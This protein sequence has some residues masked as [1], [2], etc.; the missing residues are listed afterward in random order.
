MN[1]LPL[2]K[3][4]LD[5]LIKRGII[6]L[7]NP[8]LPGLFK[9]KRNVTQAQCM[10]RLRAERK[11]L[12]TTG[13]PPRVQVKGRTKQQYQRWYYP[14]WRNRLAEARPEVMK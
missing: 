7:Q 4:E 6:R 2:T 9:A 8:E 3:Q 1:A 14:R 13:Y 10:A 5:C 11:G 12:D